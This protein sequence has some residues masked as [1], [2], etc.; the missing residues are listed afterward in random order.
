MSKKPIKK[1]VTQVEVLPIQMDRTMIL[2]ILSENIQVMNKKVRNNRIRDIEKEKVKVTQMKAVVYACN[3][4]NNILKDDQVDKLE[5]EIEF[6]KRA[7]TE[8]K[9]KE[10]IAEDLEVVEETIKKLNE[11][12]KE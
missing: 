9:N 6:I 1:N 2:D 5:R 11:T 10:K 12:N 8:D 7:I 4:Y 3:V